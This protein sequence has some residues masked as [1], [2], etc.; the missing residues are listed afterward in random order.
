VC[1][2]GC[3]PFF[4]MFL[5]ASLW[6]WRKQHAAGAMACAALATTIRPTGIFLIGALAAVLIWHRRWRDSLRSVVIVAVVGALY[7]APMVFAAKDTMAPVTG[8]AHDWYGAAT[9][10]HPWTFHLKVGF[11][12][13]LTLFGVV[14]LWKRRREAFATP[15]GQVESLFFLLFAAFCVSYNSNW[16]Y[17]EYPRFFV[18]IV[19]QSVLGHDSLTNGC[20][21]R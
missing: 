14:T 13:L 5:L 12:V 9:C 11:C 8:Y 16:V 4:I 2:G 6:L 10:G 3:E 7:L 17:E 21:C 1:L 20:C 19:P 15:V 18:P